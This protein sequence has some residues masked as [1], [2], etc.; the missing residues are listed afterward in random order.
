MLKR[1]KVVLVG[2]GGVGSSFAYALTIDNSLVH[3]LII[4]DLAQDK[5]KGE[6]MDLNHGQ[7]FLEK[8]IKIEFGNYDDCSDAD[9]VVITAGLNQKPGETRLDLVGKNTKIFKEIVTSVVS[10]GFSGIFVIASNPVDIMTYVT[11]KYSNFPTHKVIGTGTTLDT[12]RLRYFLAERFNVNTQNIH[13]YIMG[14]H[15]D[16]SFATWDETKIAMKSLSE[17]LAEGKV[18]DAELDEMHKNVVNAAYEVIK[19]KGATY[20]AIGLGIK[21]IVNAIISDQNLI[22]PISSYINGQ[23]GNFVKDIYIGAPSVVCKDGIKEVLD[24]TISDREL[25]K[26]KISASQLKSYIDKIEF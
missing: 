17:Y 9:I 12:S 21:K 13:S 22:L 8:N 6:V 15:G 11:M 2:A 1:N 3:E 23:Y 25:E 5:A 16:S 10:S 4:I 7:M 18:S 14:E 26:F 20:Y 24:F 19:L